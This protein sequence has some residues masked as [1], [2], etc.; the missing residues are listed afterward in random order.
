MTWKKILYVVVIAMTALGSRL[1]GA[2]AGG[3]GNYPSG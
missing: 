2:F 1:T 3:G